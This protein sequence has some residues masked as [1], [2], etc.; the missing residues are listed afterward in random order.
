MTY[1]L[2]IFA[3]YIGLRSE[4]FI[5]RHMQDLLP[6]QTA[7]VAD[8]SDQPVAGHWRVEGPQLCLSKLQPNSRQRL[9]D[10]TFRRLGIQ[11][12][13]T[14][15][16]RNVTRF[17]RRHGVR[18]VM[19]E[20]LS[21]SLPWLDLIHSIDIRFFA[22]A[23]GFDVSVNLREAR[24]RSEYI[25]LNQAAGVITV[26]EKS[27]ARL[28]EV[29]LD[30]R[31]IHV[32]PC[33]VDVPG[34]FLKRAEKRTI[35]CLAVGRMVSKKAP[36][37]LLDAFRRAAEICPELRLD[38]VGDGELLAAALQFLHAFDIADRVTLHGSQPSEVVFEL[39]RKADVFMQHSIVDPV[40]G[41]EEGL[42]VAV[43]E[44]MAYALPVLSTKHAGIPEAVVENKTGYL[45]EEGDSRAM[46]DRLV[47]LARDAELR[48]RM[49]RAG[50]ERATERFSWEKEAIQLRQLLGVDEQ[51]VQQPI[52]IS[53]GINELETPGSIC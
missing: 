47:M 10:S 51:R 45:V 12:K 42:P 26:S 39:L 4:T 33:G 9:W 13:E 16:R 28:V 20:Y 50:W 37:L 1:P 3:P 44:A 6:G 34:E 48:Q 2:A 27:K 11:R 14:F 24:W 36:I 35:H 8:Y 15:V 43:L 7:V 5:R 32:I 49:G 41:D 30:E 38:Y 31:K 25:R 52:G 19:G 53:A 23:H 22:H 40:T 29:G 46:A 17:L 18:V 21:W